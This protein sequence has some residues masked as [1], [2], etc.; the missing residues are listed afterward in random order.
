[1]AVAIISPEPKK[2]KRKQNAINGELLD[3]NVRQ[4]QR[5]DLT[6][7]GPAQLPDM[8]RETKRAAALAYY[9][10]LHDPPPRARRR[11]A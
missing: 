3:P 11:A 5:T 9:T 1:M 4:G 2:L 6:V 8:P 10:F 7:R